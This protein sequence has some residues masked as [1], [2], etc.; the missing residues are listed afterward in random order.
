MKLQSCIEVILGIPKTLYFNFKYLNLKE[1]IRLPIVLSNKVLLSSVKGSVIINC[2]SK[3]GIIKI[4]FNNVKNFDRKKRRTIWSVDGKVIFYGSARIGH[5]SKILVESTGKL[6]IGD[7][8]NITAEA[9]IICGKEIEFG[10]NCL[11]SWE[12][13]I[14]DKDYHQILDFGDNIL[15]NSKKITFGD[16]VWIGSRCTI[17]KGVSIANNTVIASNSCVVNKFT[18][19]NVIIGGNPGKIIKESIKWKH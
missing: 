17:L 16:N 1:A 12:N 7:D 18:K 8:F 5:G 4:G 13:Q 3:T 11:V 15:N 9:S 14:M 10:R 19:E 6:I 2:M